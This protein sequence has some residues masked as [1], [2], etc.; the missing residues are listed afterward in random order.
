MASHYNNLLCIHC[1]VEK[2]KKTLLSC[3]HCNLP[4]CRSDKCS[5]VFPMHN[6]ES[7]VIC[8]LCEKRIAKKFVLKF[9]LND[10]K[11]IKQKIKTK[12]TY[13]KNITKCKN[14]AYLY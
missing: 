10:L 12:T 1:T 14:I 2:N 8:K 11:L 3:S 4:V 13:R 7:I 5:M 9:N 6:K